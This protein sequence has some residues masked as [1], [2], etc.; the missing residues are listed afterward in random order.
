MQRMFLVAAIGVIALIN[1]G[2][3]S[4]GGR[5]VHDMS[6]SWCGTTGELGVYPGVRTDATIVFTSPMRTFDDDPFAML[7]VPFWVADM[8]LSAVA[9]TCLLPHDM[10]MLNA[11][12]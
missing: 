10:K 6:R 11:T 7:A 1:I 4:L 3:G 2:C 9:D 5:V 12:N 8:P